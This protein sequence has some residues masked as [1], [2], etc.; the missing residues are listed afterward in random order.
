MAG[1][2]HR[3]LAQRRWGIGSG[4]A[5]GY[6]SRMTTTSAE[7]ILKLPGGAKRV[8]RAI[9]VLGERANRAARKRPLRA[10][11][12]LREQRALLLVLEGHVAPD[13]TPEGRDARVGGGEPL[14]PE[15]PDTGAL[16]QAS[17]DA[18]TEDE[19]TDD[20]T[21]HLPTPEEHAR[22]IQLTCTGAELHRLRDKYGLS[23]RQAAKLL[24][25]PHNSLAKY[26]S[27]P[28]RPLPLPVA[29]RFDEARQMLKDPRAWDFSESDL[30]RPKR[31][32]DGTLWFS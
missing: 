12:W 23:L 4:T 28:G 31:M 27:M 22:A 15:V 30:P 9:L 26:E 25:A 7:R 6:K 21:C 13:A 2:A 3:A 29:L 1:N 17:E 16:D 5:T 11:Q 18:D 20:G 8:L 32:P 10:Q 19:G 14:E 24:D